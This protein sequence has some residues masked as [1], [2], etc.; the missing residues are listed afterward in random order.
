MIGLPVWAR[1][2]IDEF[3]GMN[4]ATLVNSYQEPSA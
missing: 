2:S 4:A 1:K 3:G